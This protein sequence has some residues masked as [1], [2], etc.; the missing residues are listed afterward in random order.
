MYGGKGAL[1]IIQMKSRCRYWYVRWIYV[2]TIWFFQGEKDIIVSA[3]QIVNT[4][5]KIK[6]RGGKVDSE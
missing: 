4:V 3:N 6:A 1:S 5:D 2:Q